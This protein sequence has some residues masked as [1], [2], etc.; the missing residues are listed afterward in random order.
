VFL[1][2]D[3]VVEFSTFRPTPVD[4]LSSPAPFVIL[5]PSITAVFVTVRES[6]VTE[7]VV[8][9]GCPIAISLVSPLIVTPVP[10]V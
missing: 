4:R 3:A 2:A 9:T 8:A 7:S 10:A 5:I 6:N 1:V